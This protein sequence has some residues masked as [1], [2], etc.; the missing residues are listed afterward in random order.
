M[1]S[2]NDNRE[3]SMF[4][5]MW[6]G[7][8]VEFHSAKW[9][10]LINKWLGALFS[11]I[12]G[13][14]RAWFTKG[15][16][17]ELAGRESTVR[18]SISRLKWLHRS[19]HDSCL[20]QNKPTQIAQLNQFYAA[21]RINGGRGWLLAQNSFVFHPFLCYCKIPTLSIGRRYQPP[22]SYVHP[23]EHPAWWM[24]NRI[25]L[26]SQRTS[27]TNQLNSTNGHLPTS[28]RGFIW[29]ID[30]RGCSALS[31]A[32]RLA[33]ATQRYPNCLFRMFWLKSW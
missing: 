27:E 20:L 2:L 29:S 1:S 17:A 13:A 24:N 11:P 8:T 21:C 23:I 5:L 16:G 14:S 4:N 31:S 7:L 28:H 25:S 22:V 12:E 6:G 18:G 19:K 32:Q 9:D 30:N 26:N 33:E 3:Q 15:L 10:S